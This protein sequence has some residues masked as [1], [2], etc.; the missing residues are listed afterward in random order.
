MR[1][2]TGGRLYN[3]HPGWSLGNPSQIGFGLPRFKWVFDAA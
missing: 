1:V 2:D 3:E